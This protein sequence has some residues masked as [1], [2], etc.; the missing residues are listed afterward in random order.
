VE[1]F[2]DEQERI[3]FKEMEG[4]THGFDYDMTVKEE[5]LWEDSIGN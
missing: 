1:Q 5:E 2:G 4:S 3:H